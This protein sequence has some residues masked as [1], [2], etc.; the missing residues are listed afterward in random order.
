MILRTVRNGGGLAAA[1]LL[2]GAVAGCQAPDAEGAAR[3][4]RDLDEVVAAQRRSNDELRERL[5]SADRALAAA[6]SEAERLRGTD[7]AYQE[8]AERLR[9]LRG[10]LEETFRDPAGGIT[11]EAAEGGALRFIVQGE[12][13]FG[14]GEADLTEEGRAAVASVAAALKGRREAVRVEGHTDTTPISRPETKARYPLGNLELSLHRALK[15]ADALIQAGVE[16]ARVSAA[17]WGE[18]RP[19]ADNGTVEGKR[20][21]R[22][23]EILLS[24]P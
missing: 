1:L 15:V 17:G 19:R 3:R 2:S 12:V 14:S 4:V 21:N 9:R 24:N 6:R 23:V 22:R 10:E 7:A 16:G 20:R 8:A 13:L 11:V 18:Y 5:A